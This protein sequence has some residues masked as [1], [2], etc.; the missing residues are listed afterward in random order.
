MFTPALVW[1]Y[2]H[3]EKVV[4]GALWRSRI[5]WMSRLDTGELHVRLVLEDE[6]DEAILAPATM[7][8]TGG[9]MPGPLD[10][11]FEAALPDGEWPIFTF[12]IA[13]SESAA[14]G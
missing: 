5:G 3:G 12:E 4:A 14:A 2:R 1:L 7:T 9:D 11:A 13:A 8:Y 10:L 6:T